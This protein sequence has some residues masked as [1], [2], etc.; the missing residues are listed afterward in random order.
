[1]FAS[2]AL[3]TNSSIIMVL[4]LVLI[5]FLCQHWIFVPGKDWAALTPDQMQ[6]ELWLWIELSIFFSTI[7]SGAAFT[8]FCSLK[9][10]CFHV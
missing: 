2:R 10:I 9:P 8:F 7:V 1:M 6:F 5:T 4:S 3:N